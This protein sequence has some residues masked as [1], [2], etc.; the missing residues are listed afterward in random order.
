MAYLFTTNIAKGLAGWILGF[1]MRVISLRRTVNNDRGLCYWS[2]GLEWR[3]HNGNN[4]RSEQ[5]IFKRSKAFLP[6][7]YSF[8]QTKVY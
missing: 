5:G 3:R 7:F 4:G 8:S 2:T 6:S 1:K